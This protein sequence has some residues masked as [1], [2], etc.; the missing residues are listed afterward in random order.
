M[1]FTQE[2][3]RTPQAIADI[4]VRLFDPDPTGSGQP[5]AQ[6]NV[7]VRLSDGS[8]RVRSGDLQPHLTQAQINGLLAFMAA[9]R[10]KANDEIL[11]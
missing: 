1:A 3:T 4:E 6:Y 11:P 9:M 10:V 2:A 7:Q 8:V 5:S